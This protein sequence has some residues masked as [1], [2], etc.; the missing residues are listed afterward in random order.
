M[1]T[2]PDCR[3]APLPP[4]LNRQSP[5]EASRS[6]L[7][8]NERSIF[9]NP[10]ESTLLQVFILKNLKSFGI[11]TYEKLRGGPSSHGRESSLLPRRTANGRSKLPLTVTNRPME[12][13]SFFIAKEEGSCAPFA[14]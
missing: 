14:G 9:I 5:L 6:D 2:V 3:T 13:Q 10:L 4:S 7:L 1:N 12:L 8:S 11:N